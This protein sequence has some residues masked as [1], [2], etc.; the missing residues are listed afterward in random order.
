MFP[1]EPLPPLPLTVAQAIGR[2]EGWYS[3]GQVANRPQ[4]NNNPGDIEFGPFTEANGAIHGDPRFAVFPDAATG[5]AALQALL[6][7]P[8]YA[9]LT[10]AEAVARYAP[11]SENNTDSYVASVCYWTGKQESDLVSS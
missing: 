4:R 6:A 5:W 3:Q 10:I 7:T 1:P 11:P 8:E 9:T 2:M